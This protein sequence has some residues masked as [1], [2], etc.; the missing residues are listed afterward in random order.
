MKTNGKFQKDAMT[1]DQKFRNEDEHLH[2]LDKRH[3]K[4]SA[5]NPGP[6]PQSGKKKQQRK[7]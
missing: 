6:I 3:L 5:E 2:E 7:D 1:T 4:E